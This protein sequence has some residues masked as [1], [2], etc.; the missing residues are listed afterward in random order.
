M[1]PQGYIKVRARLPFFSSGA[2][3]PDP[4]ASDQL[5]LKSFVRGAG[6]RAVKIWTTQR[7]LRCILSAIISH[8]T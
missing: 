8:I 2:R 7:F 6:S 3:V 1:T 5:W 4:L